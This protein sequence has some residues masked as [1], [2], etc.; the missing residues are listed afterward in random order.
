MTAP[1][2]LVGLS[3]VGRNGLIGFGFSA[4]LERG[5]ALGDN[6][7][8]TVE[9]KR[10]LR[11]ALVRGEQLWPQG[12]RRFVGVLVILLGILGFLPI[13]RFWMIPLGAALIALDFVP[14]TET[15]VARRRV[16]RRRCSTR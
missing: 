15:M 13:L 9:C 2:V 10:W 1:G 11:P 16:E 5:V 6:G 12:M 7:L 8:R 4:R 14:S 3:R